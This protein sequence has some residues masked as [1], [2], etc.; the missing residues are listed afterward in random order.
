M[1]SYTP[2]SPVCPDCD[3]TLLIKNYITDTLAECH[4]CGSTVTV[5]HVHTARDISHSPAP[6]R[7]VTKFGGFNAR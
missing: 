7:D 2:A 3:T 6:Q 4:N 1:S 5:N